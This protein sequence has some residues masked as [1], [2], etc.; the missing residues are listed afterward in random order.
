[1][2]LKA[3]LRR[4]RLT[5]YIYVD[6]RESSCP[7]DSPG[8]TEKRNK[9]VPLICPL[10]QVLHTGPPPIQLIMSGYNRYYATSLDFY[11]H[12]LLMAH[13]TVI[14]KTLYITIDCPG[15]SGCSTE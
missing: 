5:D 11:L 6:R 1:M 3:Q 2:L 14:P 7:S 13:P 8:E 9:G 4:S 12:G 10:R 15:T